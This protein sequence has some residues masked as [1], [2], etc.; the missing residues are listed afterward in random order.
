[1]G[2]ELELTVEQAEI[3]VLFLGGNIGDETKGSNNILWAIH[4]TLDALV[5]EAK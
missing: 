3:L 1:M 5:E 4:D 2:I